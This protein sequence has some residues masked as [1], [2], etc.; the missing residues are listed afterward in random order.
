MEFG[1]RTFLV[2]TSQIDLEQLLNILFTKIPPLPHLWLGLEGGADQ[3]E[4][5]KT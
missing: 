5:G 4:V 1:F 3:R 2:D